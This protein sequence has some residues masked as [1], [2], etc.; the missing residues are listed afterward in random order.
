M[1]TNIISFRHNANSR[2][3]T[4]RARVGG[5]RLK[6]TKGE[7]KIKD[8]VKRL[9][10]KGVIHGL[11][12]FFKGQNVQ[13]KKRAAG[14]QNVLLAKWRT[15]KA[16]RVSLV[17]YAVG[18]LLLR[19][20]TSLATIIKDDGLLSSL[21]EQFDDDDDAEVRTKLKDALMRY[22][23]EPVC[24]QLIAGHGVEKNDLP[25]VCMN[26]RPSRLCVAFA[27]SL[28]PLYSPIT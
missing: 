1:A 22:I 14:S 23:P 3:R 13:E 5:C 17:T 20:D 25:L 19:S 7:G 8:F 16:P 27:I 21:R 12:Y 24:A 6:L 28:K 11:G 2:N 26:T 4:H 15:E 18:S 9:E 10:L